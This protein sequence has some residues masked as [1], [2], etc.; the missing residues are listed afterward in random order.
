M[1]R[2]PESSSEGERY[3]SSDLSPALRVKGAIRGVE[4]LLERALEIESESYD[5]L[6]KTSPMCRESAYN[7]ARYVAVRQ[8]GVPLSQHESGRLGLRSL[9]AVEA[10][11]ITSLDAILKILYSLNDRSYL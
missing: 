10:H 11:V 1:S 9:G 6:Q 2:L 3:T 8:I 4:Q 7:L 5:M